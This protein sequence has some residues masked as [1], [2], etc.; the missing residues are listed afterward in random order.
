MKQKAEFERSENLQDLS[1]L[2]R[3]THLQFLFCKIAYILFYKLNCI[4]LGA[5]SWK[6]NFLAPYALQFNKFWF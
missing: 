3:T 6:Y 5:M 1:A 2:I 4:G